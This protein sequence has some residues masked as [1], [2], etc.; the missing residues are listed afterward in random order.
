M[1]FRLALSGLNAASAD[2]GVTANNIANSSTAGFKES[3]AEFSGWPVRAPSPN[4]NSR[5]SRSRLSP[6]ARAEMQR[7]TSPGAAT[8]RSALSRPLEPPSSP[9]ETT[10]VSEPA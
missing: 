2:L 3:R 8:P 10:P 5:E 7:R 4:R 9:T 1:P 6:V